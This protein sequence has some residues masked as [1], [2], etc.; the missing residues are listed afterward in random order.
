MQPDT[1]DFSNRRLIPIDREIVDIKVSVGEE[2]LGHDSASN[3]DFS[4]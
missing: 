2:E 1:G 3:S 4:M